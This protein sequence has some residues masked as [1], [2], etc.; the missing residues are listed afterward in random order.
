MVFLNSI[1][2]FVIMAPKNFEELEKMLE[3]G[4][5]LNKPVAIRY[6]RGGEGTVKF[7]NC[8]EIIL[9]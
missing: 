8:K 4:V 6:P 5:N 1:P 2:N 7:T 9:R 3:F